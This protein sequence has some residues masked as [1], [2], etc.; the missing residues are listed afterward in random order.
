MRDP[1]DRTNIVRAIRA[2]VSDRY[3]L[4]SNLKMV[5]ELLANS[6]HFARTPVLSWQLTD[7]G[8]RIRFLGLDTSTAAFAAFDPEVLTG[9]P[10]PVVDVWNSET[11][12]GVLGMRGGLYN[13][14]TATGMG[15]YDD[16][17]TFR[18]RH[19]GQ[20]SKMA[21]RFA[22]A[23]IATTRDANQLIHEYTTASQVDVEDME[24]WVKKHLGK[25]GEGVPDRVI[26]VIV[27]ALKDPDVTP[28]S[29][30]TTIV[31]AI[32]IAAS[33]EDDVF[34]AA[35]IEQ[36]GSRLMRK[37]L[38]EAQANNGVVPAPPKPTAKSKVTK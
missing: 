30:L 34:T 23:Y 12:R 1:N 38:L 28:G 7:N 2:V 35:D 11:A 17:R 36:A 22:G 20:V 26:D 32:T 18:R 16:S 19:T 14:K 15:H 5:N 25:K 29:K 13:V 9:E 31:D 8:I 6:T 37:G 3:A 27:A 33:K 10:L 4:F 24:T 21:S